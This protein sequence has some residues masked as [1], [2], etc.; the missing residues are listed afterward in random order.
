MK[1][2]MI[3]LPAG[4]PI[5]DDFAQIRTK[6]LRERLAAAGIPVIEQA[7]GTGP[8]GRPLLQRD[9][10]S[11]LAYE[12]ER[13]LRGLNICQLVCLTYGHRWPELVPGFKLPR[14][15]RIVPSP[16][17]RGVC[18]VTELCTRKV[19]GDTCG[20]KR[21]SLTLPRGVYDRSHQRS[22]SYDDDTWEIRPTS[23]RLSRLDFLDEIYRRMGRSLFP[24]ELESSDQ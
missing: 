10:L 12:I 2:A 4:D 14:G 5:E 11:D 9:I 1:A 20:T 18:L 7:E 22:Y 6:E 19:Q 21:T 17:R 3:A 15:F 16:E 23:S 13:Y 8:D 24:A